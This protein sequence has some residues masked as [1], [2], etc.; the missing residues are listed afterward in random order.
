MVFVFL[1]VR[2]RVHVCDVDS[3]GFLLWGFF[4]CLAGV[5]QGTDRVEE[6]VEQEMF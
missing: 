3:V 6:E 1:C 2:L 5:V 4:V